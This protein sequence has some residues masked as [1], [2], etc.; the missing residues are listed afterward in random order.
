MNHDEPLEIV[1]LAEDEPVANI[2][3]ALSDDA[4]AR[5]SA[6]FDGMDTIIVVF[7]SLSVSL[8]SSITR[9]VLEQIRARK[10][11]KIR[12]GKTIVEG[13]SQ[14]KVVEL[15]EVLTRNAKR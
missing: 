5:E 13:L 6:G 7:S 15:M 3:K 10:H 9:I 14:E 4:F 1:L 8:L 2:L 11:I 12:H